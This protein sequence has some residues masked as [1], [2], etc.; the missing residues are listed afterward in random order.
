MQ[1]RGRQ[2]SSDVGRLDVSSV[3]GAGCCR[4]VGGDDGDDPASRD[5]GADLADCLGPSDQIGEAGADVAVG[6]GR[7]AGDPR[8]VQGPVTGGDL[9]RRAD[10][11][12]KRLQGRAVK[13]VDCADRV[14]RLACGLCTQ[15]ARRLN[16]WS[17]AKVCST[18]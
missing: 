8:Q 7:S 1:Q 17:R 2:Q 16:W 9:G 14:G 3:L 10:D 11:A 12:S 15:T 5:V 18:T 6:R 13:R 4:Q